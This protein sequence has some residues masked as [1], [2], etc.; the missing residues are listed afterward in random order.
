MTSEIVQPQKRRGR[1]P[2]GKGVPVQVRLQPE[3]LAKVD[4]Y[5]A[6]RMTTRPKVIIAMIEAVEKLGGLADEDIK[7]REKPKP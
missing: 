7:R 5:A 1:T 4:A 2:T 3:L 6:E